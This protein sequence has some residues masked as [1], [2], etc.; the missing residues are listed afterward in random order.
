MM[1]IWAVICMYVAIMA[2]LYIRY[3]AVST[4]NNWVRVLRWVLCIIYYHVYTDPVRFS[5]VGTV[6]C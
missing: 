2:A 3:S 6:D 4:Y 1:L 5:S